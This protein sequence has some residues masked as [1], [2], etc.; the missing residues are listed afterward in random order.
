MGVPE[1]NITQ[2][3]GRLLMRTVYG[4]TCARISW[5]KLAT[6]LE[7]TSTQIVGS[8]MCL[9]ALCYGRDN[10]RRSACQQLQILQRG[11]TNDGK[12][13]TIS[14]IDIQDVIMLHPCL[15]LTFDEGAISCIR[16]QTSA[17]SIKGADTRKEII[18]QKREHAQVLLHKVTMSSVMLRERTFTNNYLP[19]HLKAF[20][21]SK[22][23]GLKRLPIQY[24]MGTI[25]T[26]SALFV[27]SILVCMQVPIFGPAPAISP[28]FCLSRKDQ[29]AS[30][31]RI[32]DLDSSVSVQF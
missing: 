4:N 21:A 1:C 10:V 30:S 28:L 24:A 12:R 11:R 6:N 29:Y 9:S 15:R 26:S 13:T 16:A 19:L 31:R 2:Q 5:L 27:A 22:E 8:R 14:R 7:E 3:L 17:T 25:G 23:I 18:E 32:E 20:A